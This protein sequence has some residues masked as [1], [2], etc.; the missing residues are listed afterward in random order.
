MSNHKIV[1]NTAIV[2]A[3][4]VV[5]K[6]LSYAVEALIAATLGVGDEADAYA[7]TT[8]VFNIIYPI[9]DIGIWNVFLPT[10][11]AKLSRDGEDSADH[12]A[13]A[14]IML[15]TMITLAAVVFLAVFSGPI[16]SVVTPGFNPDKQALAAKLLRISAP[17]YVLLALASIIGA[18]LQSY[19]RYLG[20]QLR[21]IGSHLSKIIFM[22]ITFRCYG[23]VAAVLAMIVGSI[24]RILIQLPFINWKWRFR[25]E[26]KRDSPDIK[27]MI[28]GLPAAAMTSAIAHINGLVDKIIASNGE[29]GAISCLNYGHKLMSV[30]NGLFSTA[31]STAT[32]PVII[33][34]IS[35]GE[36]EELKQ[37][38][39]R[40]LRILLFLIIPVTC[41]CVAF[42]QE[43]VTLAFERGA[44]DHSATLITT[45][46]FA[47]YS[48]Q[49]LPQA[50]T[51]ILS[52]VYYGY[53]DPKTILYLSIFNI[54]L[55]LGLNF[56]LFPVMGVSGLAFATSIA[57]FITLVVKFFV[58]R[59]HIRLTLRYCLGDSGKVLLVSLI[60]VAAAY[61]LFK[62]WLRMPAILML[63]LSAILC[64]VL[65][66][67]LCTL[68][69]IRELEEAKTMIRKRLHRRKG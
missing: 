41:F 8:S 39:Y 64:L 52:N 49:M 42:S 31:I 3:C 50:L 17:S 56:L 23:V 61:L 45:G 2:L 47:G 36:E 6:L 66:I 60:C 53:K 57:T 44:F 19:N 4:A 55:N 15:F 69:R 26:L 65:F 25:P 10:Y 59:K 51:T 46:I 11:K 32:Y 20:S 43:I 68:L 29:S 7:A 33:E 38:I 21:E 63:L 12:I 9:L 5:A 54:T 22:L 35:R 40:T 24:F 27:T 14:A 30:F 37:L 16:I 48:L 58:I 18:M 28:R 1:K 13:N 62:L 34:H 67:G